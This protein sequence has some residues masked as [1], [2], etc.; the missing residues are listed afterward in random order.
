MKDDAIPLQRKLALAALAS[1]GLVSGNAL[2]GG[3]LLYEVGTADVGLASAGYGA[4]AQDAA[5][6]F[7]NPAG[8]TRLD[9]SQLTLGAQLLYGDLRFSPSAGT[10]PD[11]GT[12]DG[13][14]PVGWF[15][16]GGAFFSHSVSP[17]LKLGFAMTGNFGL[18]LK[19]DTGWVGR[20]YVQEAT[21][22]GVSFLPSVAY[23]VN[24]KLSLGAS[25]NAMYGKLKNQVAINVPDPLRPGVILPI[26]RSTS[27]GRLEL[28]DG[29]W[30]WGV[31]LGAMYEVSPATRVGLT[32]NSQ[33]KLKFEPTLEFSS[34]PAGYRT[35]L[36]ATGLYNATLG[37]DITVPQ[38][39]M[40]SGFHQATDRWALLASVGWQQWSKF[41]RPQIGLVDSGNPNTITADLDYKDTWHVAAGAQYRI[42]QPW[43]LNFGIAY[44]SG[45]QPSGHISP[46]L[47]ANSQWRFG[48]GLQND[49]SQTFNWGLAAEWAYGGDLD[50]NNRSALPVT[51]GGRG[52]LVGSFNNASVFF[53]AANFNWKF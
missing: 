17:D 29:T 2:A 11:L 51:A 28:D 45:F 42:S 14:N 30:G 18:A 1:A 31:N 40:L 49:V 19:Y 12:N 50:V 47:P 21:L 10:S 9:G 36:Q 43:L 44:D 6:V 46:A 23:R 25:V 41:G 35:L 24:E 37:L 38:Q 34:L 16:G 20:Y 8:M 27:D 7:T 15:P 4:R 53:L 22:V 39:V 52:D 3:L 32:W 48:V 5:T 13:G 33:V 26:N